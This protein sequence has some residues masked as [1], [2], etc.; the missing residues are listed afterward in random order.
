MV[1]W[2]T[3]QPSSPAWPTRRFKTTPTRPS[4]ASSPSVPVSRD[5]S[6]LTEGIEPPAPF[7][8]RGSLR[9]TGPADGYLVRPGVGVW[10]DSLVSSLTSEERS[11]IEQAADAYLTAM[12]AAD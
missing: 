11:A 12:K 10:E 7:S 1:R 9:N 5:T 8:P 6:P 3:K 4:T 2:S